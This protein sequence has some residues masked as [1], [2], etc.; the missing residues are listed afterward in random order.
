MK[1]FAKSEP[2]VRITIDH[3]RHAFSCANSI[4]ITKK[5]GNTIEKIEHDS[6][7]F[8]PD[9]VL[10]DLGIKQALS[11]NQKF[12][13][14]IRAADIVLCSE[15][16]RC[17]ET[18]VIAC[19]N[20]HQ[21]V[22]VIPHVSETDSNYDNLPLEYN[23]SIQMNHSN[24]NYIKNIRGLSKLYMN[25]YY[26]LSD[27]YAEIDYSILYDL[28]IFEPTL[29]NNK[30]FYSEVLPIILKK[31][32]VSS[33]KNNNL[34][35]YHVLLFTHYG[36]IQSHFGFKENNNTSNSLNI[37]KD[38]RFIRSNEHD[39]FNDYIDMNSP[40]N[41]AIYTEIILI[42]KN[43]NMW[44][45]VAEPCTCTFACT[46]TN[47]QIKL[48]EQN[49]HYDI[50]TDHLLQEDVNRC[51]F[52]NNMY[53]EYYNKINSGKIYKKIYDLNKKNFKYLF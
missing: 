17:M 40:Y 29:S 48:K 15:L 30:K 27:G 45:E 21:K 44:T 53:I 23:P 1:N 4:H 46:E 38:P 16:R 13:Q 24:K 9:S 19:K 37:T 49:V 51:V 8:S 50:V 7:K 35:S 32:L 25:N 43:N 12:D 3:I 34:V 31:L 2:L 10:T 33:N 36:H 28:N 22:Y 6:S 41:T 20:I 18:A 26:P 47:H 11:F 52:D 5:E 14:R 39:H 42:D